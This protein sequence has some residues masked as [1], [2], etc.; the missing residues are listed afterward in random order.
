MRKILTYVFVLL[1]II[2]ITACSSDDDNN[3]NN[4]LLIGD[5][6]IVE[7]GYTYQIGTENEQEVTYDTTL[8]SYNPIA[9]FNS[10]GSAKMSSISIN[11]NEN[12]ILVC[13]YLGEFNGNWEKLNNNNYSITFN[14]ETLNVEVVFSNN[15]NIATLTY[16]YEEINEED[17]LVLSRQ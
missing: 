10:S 16:T 12:E 7:L 14:G 3:S 6:N 15:N 17:R 5:W 13:E 2:T 11:G 1:S 4:D 8:C 9:E